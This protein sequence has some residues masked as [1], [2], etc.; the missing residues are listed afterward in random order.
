MGEITFRHISY[1]AKMIVKKQ[2]LTIIIAVK[3][4]QEGGLG[5]LTNVLGLDPNRVY[6]YSVSP[7]I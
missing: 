1:I 5:R 3:Q 6:M 7:K 2:L 4:A